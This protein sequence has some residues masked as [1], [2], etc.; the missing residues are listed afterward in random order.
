MVRLEIDPE[1]KE[2]SAYGGNKKLTL[3]EYIYGLSIEKIATHIIVK[4]GDL[5]IKSILCSM[6]F[7]EGDLSDGNIKL[8]S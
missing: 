7:F 2:P 1:T 8:I 6:F 5:L 4:V 3:P